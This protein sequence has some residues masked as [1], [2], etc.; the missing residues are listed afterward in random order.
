[1]PEYNFTFDWNRITT[2]G[3]VK[4][5]AEQVVGSPS[6]E[7]LNAAVAAYIEDHP[8]AL[9][10]LSA[11]TKSAL[12][13]IAE[14][15]AYIDEHGQ[16]YYNALDAALNAR[17]LLQITAVYTQSGTVYET[18][19]LDSLKADLVVTAYYD[20]STTA[21]VTSA[22]TLSGTLTEGTSTI[23]ATYSGKSATF[24]V[25]VTA[26]PEPEWTLGYGVNGS[27]GSELT[28]TTSATRADFMNSDIQGN[29][30]PMRF[31]GSGG[32]DSPFYATAIPDGVTG[33]SV[34]N[35]G[36]G[37]ESIYGLKYDGSKWIR[38]N[39]SGWQQTYSFTFPAGST[40][41]AMA[42]KHGSAGT[43]NVTQADVD[44]VSY[45]YI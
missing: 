10:P 9:S 23:T 45:E 14:K 11:A 39:S 34:T 17:A 41:W 27:N 44:A 21:D 24:N 16:D 37:Y 38:I 25:T 15:V 6:Q 43:A 30:P 26:F 20:D 12:L 36:A 31:D 3:K 22:C 18:D 8:G 1:M 13:Q 33:V 7:A 42:M 28:I 29:Y 32:G 2:I 19:S 5:L 4:I 40:H 35:T